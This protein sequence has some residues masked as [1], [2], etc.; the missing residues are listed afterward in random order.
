MN[1]LSNKKI[2]INRKE[3]VF[4]P[5]NANNLRNSDEK[6]YLIDDQIEE[7]LNSTPFKINR[8]IENKPNLK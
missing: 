2:S 7:L 4:K 3:K 5:F 1:L 8:K 6:S